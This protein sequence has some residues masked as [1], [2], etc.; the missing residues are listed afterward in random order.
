[1]RKSVYKLKLGPKKGDM[2]KLQ[3]I[4]VFSSTQQSSVTQ[5]VANKKVRKG[6]KAHGLILLVFIQRTHRKMPCLFCNSS[7]LIIRLVKKASRSF[8]LCKF[9]P[10]IAASL[11]LYTMTALNR[12]T[13]Q[14]AFFVFQSPLITFKMLLSR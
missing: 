11:P 13:F 3:T 7:S 5:A 10:A 9:A 14:R 2:V 12:R 1:M 6:E 4:S 8:V